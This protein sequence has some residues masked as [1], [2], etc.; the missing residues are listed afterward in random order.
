LGLAGLTLL[1]TG[2]LYAEGVIKTGWI[3][4]A[5]LI[6]IGLFLIIATGA[7][8][9]VLAHVLLTMSALSLTLVASDLMLRP[10]FGQ[11]LHYTPSNV[12]SHKLPELP[13]VARWDANVQMDAESYGDLAAL[14]GD[15]TLQERRR[16]V[17]RTDAFGFRN[18]SSDDPA[19]ILI[20]GDS[21]PAGGGTTD[22]E[23][24]A[25]LLQTR[26]GFRTYNL[27][28]P[29][30][31]YDEFVNFAIEWP[32]LKVTSSLRMIWTL[33]T[34]N[35]LDDAGGDNWDLHSLPWRQGFSAWLVKYRTYR[36][37]SPLNQWTEAMRLRFRG[38]P[39]DVMVRSLPDGRPVLFAGHQEFWGTRSRQEVE[40]H[41]NFAK[42]THTLVAMRELATERQVDVTVLIL[43]TKGEVYRWL[44]DAREP[45]A[46]DAH[47]SGFA[48][49]VLDACSTAG[50]HCHDLKPYLVA[51]ANRLYDAKRELL[52]W[53]D[54]T[55]IGT[56][57]H[58]AIAEY[59]ATR[60]LHD[61]ARAN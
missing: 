49:A 50:L 26:Y 44:L 2:A 38:S 15:P 16:I 17:F 6:T 48:R 56:Y 30:G 18:L 4:A 43:P 32:R 58:A 25:R 35:D 11:R 10:A 41:P 21:F 27:S 52:W 60:L 33:Y 46:E 3:Q 9:R 31:P 40:Q 8:A 13:I 39:P 5:V 28:Y 23:T 22:E 54:D 61:H 34:G 1:S 24:F 19:D 55:H 36:N 14:A 20:V 47:S 7:C 29:G 51:E 12:S 37:R 42:L 53:R 45:Q 57:G 59:I